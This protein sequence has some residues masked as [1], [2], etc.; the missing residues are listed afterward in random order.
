MKWLLAADAYIKKMSKRAPVYMLGANHDTTAE[1]G[2]HFFSFL[3][4]Y[5]NVTFISTPK[6]FELD[7]KNVL[8]LPH[9]RNP[10]ETWKNQSYSE[11]DYIFIHQTLVGA[12]ASDHYKAEKGL[13]SEIFGT[14]KAK[15]YAG[16]VHVPQ[17]IGSVEYVGAPARLRFGDSYT[18]R[19]LLEHSKKTEIIE[20]THLPLKHKLTIRTFEDIKQYDLSAGD[21]VK[22]VVAIPELEFN[23]YTEIRSE[24]T[25]Y[26]QEKQVVLAG[27]ELKRLTRVR[28][29]VRGQS[30]ITQEQQTPSIDV[31][32]QYAKKEELGKELVEA[33]VTILEHVDRRTECI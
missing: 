9:T 6:S 1:V 19:M 29:K 13:G 4:N 30:M 33:A 22:V 25:D 27:I 23:S 15:I 3:D 26:L 2:Y 24:L 16:D 31:V 8:F 18:P 5:E 10:Y 12:V 32:S 21:M 11:F 14:T 20:M 28:L 17:V 7:G